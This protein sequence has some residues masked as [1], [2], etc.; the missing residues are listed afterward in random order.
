V[1]GS[2]LAEQIWVSVREATKI[3]GYNHDH[4]R[5][6]ARENWR[7]P[8]DQRRIRVRMDGQAYVIWLPDLISY[9]GEDN[10]GQVE[11]PDEQ[12]WVNTAE[13]EKYT[14]YNRAYLSLLAGKMWAKPESER[15][16]KIKK[17]LGGHYE[18]WLPDLLRHHRKG[19]R[20]PQGRHNRLTP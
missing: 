9:F 10:D 3:T 20:G 1:R 7:L 8:E 6:L 19:K 18:L 14:G 11:N 17:R 4:V 12:I 2:F 5:R 13:G 16:I 15:E